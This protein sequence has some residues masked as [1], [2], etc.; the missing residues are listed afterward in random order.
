MS[1][2]TEL[3]LPT[4][5]GGSNLQGLSDEDKARKMMGALAK[6]KV[7]E[8][9]SKEEAPVVK[10]PQRKPKKSPAPPPSTPTPTLRGPENPA[11]IAP[12]ELK[13]MDETAQRRQQEKVAQLKM[14][15]FAD[16]KNPKF[17]ALLEQKRREQEEEEEARRFTGK[18]IIGLGGL[19]LL[20]LAGYLV[21]TKVLP[22]SVVSNVA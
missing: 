19:A 14:S 16:P 7:Q 21:Y 18:V 20:G 2:D 4:P 6:M 17:I 15:Y 8:Q 11:K 13:G 1:Q 12:V 3:Q 22:S 5:S 9:D 10:K